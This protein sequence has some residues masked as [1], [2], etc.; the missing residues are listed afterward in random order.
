MAFLIPLAAAAVGAAGAIKGGQ[1][2]SQGQ[3]DAN[4]TNVQLSREQMAFQERLSNTAF[5]RSVLDL[6]SAGL[7]PRLAA[8]NPAST[9]SGSLARV[10]NASEGFGRGISDAATS[11]ASAAMPILQKRMMDS[12]IRNMDVNTAK[13]AAE[14]QVVQ[15]NLPYTASNARLSS[16][17]LESELQSIQQD[18]QRKVRE[19]QLQDIDINQMRP[20]V[21]EYQRIVNQAAAAGIPEKEATAKFFSTVPEAKWLAIVRAVLGR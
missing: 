2:A 20:L 9:P 14:T 13:T 21:L 16:F 4:E 15:A 5:Q 6:K 8:S 18:V 10:E 11:A 19:T 1:I 12:Q 3:R 7:N 17:K